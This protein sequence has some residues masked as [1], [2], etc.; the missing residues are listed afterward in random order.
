MRK[1]FKNLAFYL[2]LVAF[3]LVGFASMAHLAFGHSSLS[4]SSLGR[5][6]MTIFEIFCGTFNYF[7]M[8]K[9]DSFLA[10]FFFSVIMALIV[11]ILL[12]LFIS[13]LEDAYIRVKAKHGENRNTIEN[14]NF[15]CFRSLATFCD[16][17]F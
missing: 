5:S 17:K 6:C 16:V 8:K 4:F 10:P 3:F 2:I 9:A 14:D 13:I 1:A 12:N 11:F 7:E 15:E